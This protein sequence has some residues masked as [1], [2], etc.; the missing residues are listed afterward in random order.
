MSTAK[1]AHLFVDA[2]NVNVYPDQICAMH[3]IAC[4]H[5]TTFYS[6]VVVG[7]SAGPSEKPAIWRNLGY[8]VKCVER[9]CPKCGERRRE[10][11]FNV[12]DVIA[13]SMFRE[14]AKVQDPESMPSDRRT[15][16]AFAAT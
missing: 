11:E 3:A 7:S 13:G 10:S 15:C 2:S 5:F 14:I 6:A 12:D 8:M 16:A 4:E 1:I 9:N